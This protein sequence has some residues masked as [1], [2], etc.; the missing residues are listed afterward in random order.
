MLKP[1]VMCP[2]EDEMSKPKLFNAM[3]PLYLWSAE[4][5]EEASRYFDITMNWIPYN[6]MIFHKRSL[7]GI[8]E[9]VE[10]V[11]SATIPQKGNL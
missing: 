5:I 8:K 3:E 9:R 10:I 2:R 6:L 7:W 1:G 4:Q 11:L